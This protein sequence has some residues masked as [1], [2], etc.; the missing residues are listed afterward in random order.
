LGGGLTVTGMVVFYVTWWLYGKTPR[1]PFFVL[2][3]APGTLF[4]LSWLLTKHA[5]RKLQPV[6]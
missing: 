3:A 4:L 1:G 2:I 5:Q 6:E